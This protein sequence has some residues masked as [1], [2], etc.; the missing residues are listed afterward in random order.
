MYQHEMTP[1]LKHPRYMLGVVSCDVLYSCCSSIRAST[2]CAGGLV[3][4]PVVQQV[5]VSGSWTRYQ[6]NFLPYYCTVSR[7]EAEAHDNLFLE[8]RCG[9][10]PFSRVNMR[11]VRLRVSEADF[12]CRDS[13]PSPRVTAAFDSE[14]H[15]TVEPSHGPPSTKKI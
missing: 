12:S 2:G 7:A 15:G 5:A 8:I 9:E 6:L 10:T 13:K 1:C 14:V 4:Y 11:S 3:L